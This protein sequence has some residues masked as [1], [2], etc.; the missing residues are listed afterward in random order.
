MTIATERRSTPE[1][2][3]TMP[4]ADRFELVNGELVERDMGFESSWVGGQIFKRLVAW[5]DASAGGFVLPSDASYQC[6]PEAPDRVRRPDVS[7][8][9]AGRLP[10]G[11]LPKGH[12]HLAPDLAVEV[13]SPNDFY[14]EV[15]EKVSEY[16]RAGVKVVWIVDPA[17]RVVAVARVDGAN[18]RLYE[19]DELADEHLP[20]FSCRVG[21][22]LPGAGS[23]R[24]E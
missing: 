14:S 4:D 24:D 20:G 12:C 5:S 22:L 11:V 15:D 13:V 7:F 21:D 16:L 8:I 17:A 10:R 9:R 3:L 2:L 6:F 19:D 1:D 23:A 18:R